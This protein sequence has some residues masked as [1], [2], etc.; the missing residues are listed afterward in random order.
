MEVLVIAPNTPRPRT[1]PL[2]RCGMAIWVSPA[3]I[4]SVEPGDR[5]GV[6][7]AVSWTNLYNSKISQS[8][9]KR[10]CDKYAPP[11]SASA[12]RPTLRP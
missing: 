4:L 8:A 2:P 6:I 9:S 11:F 5:V 12:P 10:Y 7:V 3:G 1:R